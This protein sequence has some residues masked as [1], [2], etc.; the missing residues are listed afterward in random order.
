[1]TPEELRKRT[2][3]FAADTVRFWR[4]LPRSEDARVIGRQLLRAGTSVGANYR[5][6]CRKRSDADFIAKLGVA[7]EEADE[8]GFWIELLVEVEIVTPKRVERLLGEAEELVRIFVASRE[9]A[10]ANARA[11]GNARARITNR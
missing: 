9:T 10:R 5:A 3:K 11:R 7:I 4:T 1:M 2:K 6:V 8:A